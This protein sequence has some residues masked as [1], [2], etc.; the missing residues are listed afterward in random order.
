MEYF[1]PRN[2]KNSDSQFKASQRSSG[3]KLLRHPPFASLQLPQLRF[4]EDQECP[5]RHLQ[6]HSDG[7][8]RQPHLLSEIEPLGVPGPRCTHPRRVLPV[9]VIVAGKLRRRV[10][11]R[12]RRQRATRGREWRRRGREVRVGINGGDEEREE[13]E[14]DHG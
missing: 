14:Q 3:V 10:S 2:C 7:Q 4:L 6:R 13:E 9:A 12:R 11:S 8:K 1:N 5:Q